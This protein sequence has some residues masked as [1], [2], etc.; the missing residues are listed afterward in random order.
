MNNF[1]Q[2]LETCNN[3]IYILCNFNINLLLNNPDNFL[4][5]QSLY[6]QNNSKYNILLC[7]VLQTFRFKTTDRNSSLHYLCQLAFHWFYTS[8]LPWH[9][10]IIDVHFVQDRQVRKTKRT[11]KKISFLLLKSHLR[12]WWGIS[13]LHSKTN[14]N[15]Q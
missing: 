4:E 13:R 12:C 2:E 15:H 7:R 6:G 1:T 10:F 8:K 11:W 9:G 5:K 14:E 3:W